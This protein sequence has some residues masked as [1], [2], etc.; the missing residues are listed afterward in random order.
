M[1]RPTRDLFASFAP[2]L[3]GATAAIALLVSTAGGLVAI[4]L[5]VG[6][7]VA[8]AAATRHL[9]GAER[10]KAQELAAYV[11]GHEQFAAAVSPVWASHIET[12]R[13]QME[14]AV[15]SLAQRFAGIV[16]RLD[17]T[18]QVSDVS[19]ASTAGR[20]DAVMTVFARSE[21]ALGDVLQSLQSAMN[22]KAEL[23]TEVQA[24]AGF[25]DELQRMATDVAQI[26][27]QTNLLAINAAIEAAHA[28]EA[29]RGF[30]VLAQEVRKLSAQSGQTGSHIA[31]KIKSIS[32]AIVATRESAEHAAQRE[33]ETV[34][35]SRRTIGEVLEQF[36]GVTDGLVTSSEQ[37]KQESLGIKAEVSEALVQLQFQDRLSQILSHVKTSIEQ[38]P[39]E[40]EAQHA[41]SVSQGA[42][43]APDAQALLTALESSYAMAD[44]R[45]RHHGNIPAAAPTPA[46]EV[47]FF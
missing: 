42:L 43:R 6:L 23:L 29:G 44:E 21:A 31:E 27:Q 8:G 12:S 17:Q 47:T 38:L 7:T 15:G 25:I 28:G 3:I 41:A 26:A 46:E 18:V 10:Q 11:L 16:Q 45:E 36:R 2:L 19:A 34:L 4:A 20:G 1:I 35:Q 9:V 33:G 13:A 32:A 24:L 22:S 39:S 37:I 30:S 40:L 14:S 5:S